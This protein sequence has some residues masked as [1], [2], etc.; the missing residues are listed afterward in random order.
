MSEPHVVIHTDKNGVT[1]DTEITIKANERFELSIEEALAKPKSKK[2]FAVPGKVYP[3]KLLAG[4]R[5]RMD[6]VSDRIDSLL[7][8]HGPA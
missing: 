4:A 1:S 5:Y 2:N 7:I 3:V 8:V 6:M